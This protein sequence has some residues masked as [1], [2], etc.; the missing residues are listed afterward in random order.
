MLFLKLGHYEVCLHV[1]SGIGVPCQENMTSDFSLLLGESMNAQ[2]PVPTKPTESRNLWLCLDCETPRLL[3]SWVPQIYSH[4]VEGQNTVKCQCPTLSNPRLWFPEEGNVHVG[5]VAHF[6][7][8][9]DMCHLQG[10]LAQH[11]SAAG[12]TN[13]FVRPG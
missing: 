6:T 7:R 8:S 4:P 10:H 11:V 3:H 9:P 13:S 12:N 5:N 1:F 2:L